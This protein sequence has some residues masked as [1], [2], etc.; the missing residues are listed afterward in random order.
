MDPRNQ[1]TTLHPPPESVLKT[2][3]RKIVDK[4]EFTFD[5][6]FWSFDRRDDHYAD[7]EDV[8]NALGEEFLD[9]NFEGYH[10]C[11]F[12]YVRRHIPVLVE[13]NVLTISIRARQALGRVIQWFATQ[14]DVLG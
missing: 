12:A 14:T 3:S 11:I 8:Y 5:N 1:T 6:S 10:T 7:Q 4:K 9:H 2:N 13:L